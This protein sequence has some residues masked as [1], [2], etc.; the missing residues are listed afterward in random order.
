MNGDG[1]GPGRDVAPAGDRR[2]LGAEHGGLGPG[3]AGHDHTGQGDSPHDQ[4]GTD[5]RH[6][7]DD[8][9]HSHDHGKGLIGWVKAPS[10]TR[11]IFRIRP[12]TPWSRARAASGPSNGR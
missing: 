1:A 5:H 10:G 11:T 12:T 6:S 2:R 3:A 4:G 7:H 8:H 9:G